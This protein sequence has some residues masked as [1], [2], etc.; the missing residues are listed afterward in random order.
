M[1]KDF[2]N[3]IFLLFFIFSFDACATYYKKDISKS[4]YGILSSAVTFSSDK[5][6]GEYGDRIPADF[7]AD[8]FMQLTK[9][10]IPQEYHAVLEKYPIDI[11]PMS[12]YYLIIVMHPSDRS[13][14]LFDY[15]C[16][17]EVDGPILLKP[18]EYDVTNL[19]R[20]DKCKN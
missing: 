7:S 6:I 3:I 17:P 10:K 9:D 2:V 12:S 18:N 5:V 11:K 13:I 15:S 1:A 16:T 20:Y 19:E 8:H 14:I 4:E